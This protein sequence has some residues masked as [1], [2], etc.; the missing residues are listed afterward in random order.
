MTESQQAVRAFYDRVYREHGLTDASWIY[1]R[2]IQ[3]LQPRSGSRLLDVAC[4]EG[5]LLLYAS[6]AKLIATGLDLSI[7][8]LRRARTRCPEARLIVGDGGEL[9]FH[10]AA[11]DYVTNL[12]SLEHFRDMGQG[13]D[14]MLRV[15]KP[16]GRA[17][18]LL[19]NA[20]WLGSIL[21]VWRT[22]DHGA[23][24]QIIDRSA[25]AKQWQRLLEEHGLVVQRLLPYNRPVK[26]FDERRRLRSLRKFIW[27]G[28]LN[29]CTPFHLSWH[30][31][32]LC[33]KR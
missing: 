32:F 2:T 29:A 28:V 17:C 3:L 27:R 16:T 4:G 13:L 25:P 7:E 12:G 14:E 18:L 31:L 19:P 1:Q 5:Q 22:G 33:V 24:W 11:F 23:G 8:A 6:R 10:D 30:F 26:L 21:E 15:L 9:P 20:F